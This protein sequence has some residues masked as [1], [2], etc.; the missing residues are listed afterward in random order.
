MRAAD[1][2]ENF[3]LNGSAGKSAKLGD[4]FPHRTMTSESRGLSRRGR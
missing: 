3:A 4:E 2:F 1:L